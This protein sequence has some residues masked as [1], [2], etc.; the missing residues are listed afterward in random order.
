MLICKG[1]AVIE[2]SRLLASNV[3]VDDF[4]HMTVEGGSLDR[5]CDAG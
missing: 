4:D 5:D 1:V 3:T 2:G